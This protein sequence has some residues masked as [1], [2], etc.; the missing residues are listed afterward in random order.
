LWPLALIALVIV[1]GD[2]QARAQGDKVVAT[3]NKESITE[4]YFFNRLQRVKGQDF[5]VNT[6]PPSMRTENGGYIILNSII[7]ER[8]I[9]QLAAK[10]NLTPTP[11]E[12]DIDLVPLMKQDGVIKAI[13]Q[14]LV[15]ADDIKY[16]VTVQQARFNLSTNRQKVTPAEVQAFYDEHIDNYK[17]P[18][19]WVLSAIRT[20]KVDDAIKIITELKAG[21][22]F[23]ET[24]RTYSEDER[25]RATGGKIGV[26]DATDK[27]LPEDIR[28]KV[29]DLKSGEFTEPISVKFDTGGS[30][31]QVTVYWIVKLNERQIASQRQLADV[32]AQVEKLATLQ[33]T[34][35]LE[36]GD[37]KIA[38]FRKT[39]DIKIDLPGYEELLNP[40]PAK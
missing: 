3:I 16:D 38:D 32:R 30:A 8:L 22:T 23:E 24:A 27:S 4:G 31:G 19:R 35:G 6:K 18:E 36:V 13:A 29:R 12:I 10:D 7:N 40:P 34:G 25:T 39:S 20:T 21:K 26:F 11:A 15:T 37:K 5:L 2:G 33:K 28:N 17:S 1:I 9:L 14:H